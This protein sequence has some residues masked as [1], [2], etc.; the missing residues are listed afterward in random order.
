M[1]TMRSF[2]KD[3]DGLKEVWN[4]VKLGTFNIYFSF[5]KKLI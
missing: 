4:L 5:F 3:L 2:L 1:E